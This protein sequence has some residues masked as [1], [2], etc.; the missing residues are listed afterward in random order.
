M[1][2]ALDTARNLR[3]RVDSLTEVGT[4]PEVMTRIMELAQDPKSSALD[5][6]AAISQEPALSLKVLRTVNSAYYGLQRRIMTVPDAV[7]VLGFDEVERLALTITVIDTVRLDENGFRALRA[8][9]RHSL[10]C[11]IA[12]TVCEL[13]FVNKLEGLRGVHVAGL[14]HDIG[15]VILGQHFPDLYC[16]IVHAVKDEGLDNLEAERAILG[17]VTHCDVGSWI[18]ERWNLPE[19]LVASIRDHHSPAVEEQTNPL[20]HATHIADCVTNTLGYQSQPGGANTQVS[21]ASSNLIPL[22]EHLLGAI[23]EQLLR[24]QPLLSAVSSGCMF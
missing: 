16:R 12:C 8:L 14:L 6:A 11:S 1:T 7:V 17:G 5:L 3:Q 15:K 24:R 4:L 2:S 23:R 10:A 20:V 22:D 21:P 9:W 13:R 19:G 18:A